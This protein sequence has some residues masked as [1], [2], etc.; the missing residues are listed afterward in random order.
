[1]GILMIVL[2]I[3]L[4]LLCVFLV[5]LVLSQ[6]AKGGGLAGALG[7]GTVQTAFG[8]R[9]AESIVKL[10]TYVAIGFFLLIII[11]A[12][13][14]STSVSDIGLRDTGAAGG[15]PAAPSAPATPK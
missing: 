5:F 15:L 14:G 9:S 1:M 11:M 12:K 8:G 4:L 6:D 13:L 7:G 3:I 2:S 10:T